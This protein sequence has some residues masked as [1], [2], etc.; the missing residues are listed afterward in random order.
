MVSGS[1]EFDAD[2]P[3]LQ[4]RLYRNDG[5]GKF[6]KDVDA[7]PAMHTPG[8]V[9]APADFDRDGD[10]DLFVGGRVIPGLYPYAPFSYLLIN[11]QG[12][13]HIGTS[14]LAPEMETPGMVTA[15]QW[16]DLDKD[17]DLDL[18]LTGEWKGIEVFENESGKLTRS[19]SYP[20]VAYT[21]GWWN[22]ILVAD[23]NGDGYDDIVAGNLG[24]NSKIHASPKKPLHV[25][26]SDF[27]S[28]GTA[29][30]ML[31]KYYKDRQVP[32][33]GKGCSSHQIPALRNTIPTYKDFASKDLEGILGNS[34]KMR[35]ITR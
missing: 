29:D 12:K 33:R 1:Y 26:T 21:T 18:L 30:I 4:D 19:T 24:L 22:I 14:S 25:Y 7:L 10:M 31:A 27:D 5:N 23:L 11:D 16:N 9:V 13:F 6:T 32:V 34:L 35:C 3:L 17:G 28:N 2:S 8:S 20:A 15:A